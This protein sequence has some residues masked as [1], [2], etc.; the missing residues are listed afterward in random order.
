MS[1]DAL[2]D[3]GSPASFVQER[4]RSGRCGRGCLRTFEA[5]ISTSMRNCGSRRTLTKD[6]AE[7]MRDLEMFFERMIKFNLKL[8]PKKTNLGVKVVTFLGHQVT[9]EGIGP[10]P[11]KVRPL[12]QVPMPTNV[13]QLRSLLGSLS[14]YR[15]FLKNMS[16]KV[17]PINAMLKKG[18]K[19]AFTADDVAVVRKGIL[20]GPEVLAF[21]CYEG[22]ISGKRPFRLTANASISGLGAEIEQ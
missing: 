16:A 6:G 4:W 21:P 18:A 2:L 3:T 7:H 5:S 1:W 17:K 8:A 10:D 12:R 13:S 15:K 20:S 9:A 11:E 14:Y 22:A 19:I